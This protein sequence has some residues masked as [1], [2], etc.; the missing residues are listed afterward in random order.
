MKK[1]FYVVVPFDEVEWESVKDTSFF[2]SF[3]W[4]MASINWGDDITK[5]REQIRTFSKTKKWL[6]NRSN[7][8]KTSLENIWIKA[9]ALEKWDLIKYITDYYNPNMEDSSQI[10]QDSGEFNLTNN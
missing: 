4:F 8:I 7:Q 2:S 9:T 3:K 10:K 5:I 6:I 1:E